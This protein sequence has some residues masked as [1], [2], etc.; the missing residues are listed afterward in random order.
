MELN[1]EFEAAKKKAAAEAG[2]FRHL[3]TYLVVNLFFFL[4]NWLTGRGE[5]WFYWPLLGWGIGLFWHGMG[6]FAFGDLFGKGWE[7]RRAKKIME[8]R[9]R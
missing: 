8:R 6:V 3:V 7:E 5:W 1:P 9:N 4:L 2:F